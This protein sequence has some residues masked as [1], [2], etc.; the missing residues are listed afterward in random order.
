MQAIG[1]VALVGRLFSLKEKKIFFF[2]TIEHTKSQF[3]MD[4]VWCGE[5]KESSVENPY[6]PTASSEANQNGGRE[7]MEC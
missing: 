3:G 4:C 2:T 7:E 5:R 6:P 1:D